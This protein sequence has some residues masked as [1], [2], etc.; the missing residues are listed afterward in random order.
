MTAR[1]TLYV[2]AT[3]TLIIIVAL[4]LYRSEQ[5]RLWWNVPLYLYD[6]RHKISADSSGIDIATPGEVRITAAHT[7]AYIRLI[8]FSG[9]DLSGEQH[10]SFSETRS[11]ARHQY[12]LRPQHTFDA[13]TDYALPA[14]FPTQQTWQLYFEQRAYD[15]TNLLYYYKDL[16]YAP[17]GLFFVN[18]RTRVPI[19]PDVYSTLYVPTPEDNTTAGPNEWLWAAA[20][21]RAFVEMRVTGAL[22]RTTWDERYTRRVAPPAARH[23]SGKPGDIAW[24]DIYFYIYISPETGWKRI[25]FNNEEW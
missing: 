10:I 14:T 13:D 11:A 24:D 1:R 5:L 17:G 4:T 9:I 12:R 20:A 25:R 2:L 7:D 22:A 3:I 6:G 23:A 8:P 21:N 18:P 19:A 16:A 15:G